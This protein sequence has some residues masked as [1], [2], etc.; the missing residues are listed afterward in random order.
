MRHHISESTGNAESKP[1]EASRRWQSE[2][3]DVFVSHSS[4]DKPVA[5]AVVALLEQAGLRCWVA[6][7]DV[8]PGSLWG[9]AIV[10]AIETS[11]LMVVIISRD[12]NRSHQV[13]R[14]VERA[15]ANEVVIIP[16]RIDSIEPTG[17]MAYYLASEHWL[18]AI[19]PPLETHITHLVEVSNALLGA[20]GRLP[21]RG[22]PTLSPQP[23]PQSRRA[24]PWWRQRP[25]VVAAA[26]SLALLGV[27]A[28]VLVRLGG[29]ESTADEDPSRPQ[30]QVQA[31]ELADSIDD[32]TAEETDGLAEPTGTAA[33]SPTDHQS[34][35]ET[36]EPIVLSGRGDSVELFPTALE[37]SAVAHVVFTGDVREVKGELLP[38]EA[39]VWALNIIALDCELNRG[40][41]VVTTAGNYDG[42]VRLESGTCGLEIT[43]SPEAP[44]TVEV[45]P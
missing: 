32:A 24:T 20:D 45:M 7:R 31:Q 13:L 25:W 27:L 41:L 5:D 17:A 10:E 21:T 11:R 34:E 43:T 36:P 38:Y 30:T 3:H 37:T 4:R 39:D 28:T 12:S 8:L 40:E 18:D 26:T 33:P 14:E 42:S 29:S 35:E 9:E 23:Q 44:W 1:T 22:T 2:Q 6:P 15:V 19:N 16:F